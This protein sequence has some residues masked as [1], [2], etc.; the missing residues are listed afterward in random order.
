MRPLA[1]ANLISL[2]VCLF[3][4]KVLH[5]DL[6]Q[7]HYHVCHRRGTIVW[8]AAVLPKNKARLFS[9]NRSWPRQFE[10]AHL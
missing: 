3:I 9:M 10:V 6:G 2:D 7:K 8:L 4:L 1:L 5:T